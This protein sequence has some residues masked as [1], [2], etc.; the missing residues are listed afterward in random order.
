MLEELSGPAASRARGWGELGSELYRRGDYRNAAECFRRMAE[1]L[2]S[3]G[4]SRAWRG[5]CEFK[6][7][8]YERALLHLQEGRVR[9]LEAF[10]ELRTEARLTAGLL[11]NR[12]GEFQA[13]FETLEPFAKES[14]VPPEVLPGLGLAALQYPFLPSEVPEDRR[15]VVQLAGEATW[16]VVAHEFA[17]ADELHRRLLE[18]YPRQAGVN[19]ACGVYLAGR[20]RDAAMER[21]REELRV[22]PWH[23]PSLLQ[24]AFEYIER[25]QSGEGLEHARRALEIEP[26]SYKA[27]FAL[28]WA[29]LEQGEIE[30]AIE[31]LERAVAFEPAVPEL[32]FTLARAYQR[33]GRSEDAARQRSV[34]QELSEAKRR[35]RN[36]VKQ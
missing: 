35:L 11:L 6:L 27:L 8:D 23:V 3:D 14:V 18:Q 28:G 15:A 34:F 20:N 26:D 4:P 36:Q 32:R 5:L 17:R 24:L 33:A 10:P 12:F 7:G 30:A 21:F 2:P 16:A 1:L 9:G 29:R 19:Y 13:A 31:A 22:N 25:G